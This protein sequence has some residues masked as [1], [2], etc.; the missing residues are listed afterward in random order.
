MGK[1]MAGPGLQPRSPN[2]QFMAKF[3]HHSACAKTLFENSGNRYSILAWEI[4]WTNKPGRLQSMG[5]I[6]CQTTEQLNNNNPLSA[7]GA[8]INLRLKNSHSEGVYF[9]YM[10]LSHHV[11]GRGVLFN[12]R[13]WVVQETHVLTKQET[14]LGRG[15]WAE[16]RKVREPNRTALPHG[17]QPQVLRRSG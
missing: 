10:L 11:A 16:R 17:S 6:T 9:V 15:N 12:T 1:L 8:W 3:P 4:P 14:L 5:S 13:K 7:S 2:A